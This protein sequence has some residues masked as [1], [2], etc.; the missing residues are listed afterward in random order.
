[1]RDVGGGCESRH[2][3]IWFMVTRKPECTGFYQRFKGK[4]LLYVFWYGLEVLIV[5]FIGSLI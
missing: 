2:L 5:F 3:V 4:G 1:M